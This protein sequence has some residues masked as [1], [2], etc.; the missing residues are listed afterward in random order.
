MLSSAC[1]GLSANGFPCVPFTVTLCNVALPTGSRL[2][3]RISCLPAGSAAS[4]LSH[5][6]LSCLH[7]QHPLKAQL[8][9]L[10]AVSTDGTLCITALPPALKT[11]HQNQHTLS[12]CRF[13]ITATLKLC[14]VAL[15][16]R[17]AL[18]S[19]LSSHCSPAVQRSRLQCRFAVPSALSAQHRHQLPLLALKGSHHLYCNTC[20]IALPAALS[21]LNSAS[22][23]TATLQ[24]QRDI[25]CT[26]MQ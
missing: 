10:T 9:C 2:N 21:A 3:T 12:P 23:P 4:V 7:E 20:S 24:I 14:N 26:V 11:Q 17:P 5:F 6:V 19:S 22:E 13:N 16:V 18:T 15:L 25:C 1:T 8:C